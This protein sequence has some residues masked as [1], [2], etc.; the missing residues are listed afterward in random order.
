MFDNNIVISFKIA[1]LSISKS[2][3]FII[4]KDLF[5]RSDFK[6]FFRNPQNA[7]SSSSVMAKDRILDQA[8]MPKKPEKCKEKQKI[9]FLKTHKTA[10]RYFNFSFL[11][12]LTIKLDYI[13]GDY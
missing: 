1:R 7:S 4:N 10:S 11:T 8:L 9:G 6:L 13:T 12:G 2:K 3:F 5:L